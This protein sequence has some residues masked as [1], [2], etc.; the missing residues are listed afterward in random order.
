MAFDENLA[1]RVRAVVGA[2][3]GIV[4]QRLFGGL[5]SLLTGT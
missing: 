4:E 1:A 2:E 3:P 5:A